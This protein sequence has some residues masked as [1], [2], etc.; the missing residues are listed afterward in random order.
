MLPMIMMR[1]AMTKVRTQRK[2]R[3]GGRLNA[4]SLSC[5]L[6][7]IRTPRIKAMQLRIIQAIPKPFTILRI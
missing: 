4:L 1:M 2:I 5:L 7:T 6:I 3:L